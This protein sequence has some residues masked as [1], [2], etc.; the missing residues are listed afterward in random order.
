MLPVRRR[1]QTLSSSTNGSGSV[2]VHSTNASPVA[3]IATAGS[4]LPLSSPASI[5]VAPVQLLVPVAGRVLAA[6]CQRLPLLMDSVQA[7]TAAP[8]AFMDS[9]GAHAVLLVSGIGGVLQAVP[10]V[11]V[12]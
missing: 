9:T 5:T 10:F 6:T 4:R 11:D 2:C 3:D 12:L 8:S 7:T 1:I